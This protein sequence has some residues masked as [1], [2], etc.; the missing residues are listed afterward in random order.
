MAIV[1]NGRALARARN[2]ALRPRIA[3]LPRPPGLA[4]VL[5][6]ADPASQVYVG[7]KATVANRLGLHHQQI[8]LPTDTP[9][10]DLLAVVDR[11]NADPE[12][13]GILVQVPLPPHM[14]R[15]RVLDRIEPSKDVDGFHPWNMGLLAQGRPR[16]VAC[17]PR[18][19]MELLAEHR[20]PL[21][22]QRAV[23]VGRSTIV[24]RPVSLLLDKA[25]ATVT[26]CHSRTVDLEA[27]VREADV[28]VAAVGIPG[29]VPAAWIKPGAAVVDVGV[30]R[31]D[32]GSLVGDV[33]QGPE[34]DA[35][36][37]I[38]PVPGGVGPMTIAMLMANTVE[39][40]EGRLA[41]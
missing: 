14:D 5:V 26:V 38:T 40:A 35:A 6:G 21:Q 34:L 2:Q 19:I 8:D 24:G 12:I 10:A 9:E 13:D 17:T 3:A 27:R 39:S 22:G 18:G 16:F 28:V 37:W 25:N 20:V 15:Q 31:L 30:N 36:G 11:L 32:D 33:G 41:R 23:V 1:M 29:A 7:R 4:V